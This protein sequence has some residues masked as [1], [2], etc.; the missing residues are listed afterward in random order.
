MNLHRLSSETYLLSCLQE[1]KVEEMVTF[2]G[3]FLV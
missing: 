1:P 3:L 2:C